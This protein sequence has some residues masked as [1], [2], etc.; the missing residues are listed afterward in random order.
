MPGMSGFQLFEE[1]QKRAMR[2]PVIFITAGNDDRTELMARKLG[3]AGYFN[4]PFNAE[5]LMKLVNDVIDIKT[6]D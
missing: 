3:A 2:Y 5:L 6:S 1:L 4:K